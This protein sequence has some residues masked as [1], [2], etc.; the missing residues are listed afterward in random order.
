MGK[1]TYRAMKY[2]S[3]PAASSKIKKFLYTKLVA[4]KN[5]NILLN[6]ASDTAIPCYT[7]FIAR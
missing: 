7:T 3:I 5:L 1:I 6:P 2:K 4:F